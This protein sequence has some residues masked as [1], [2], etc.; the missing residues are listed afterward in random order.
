MYSPADLPSSTRAA[1]AK[2]RKWSELGGS[3][4]EAVRPIGLPVSRHSTRVISSARASIAS[5]I[6]SSASER[7]CGVVCPQRLERAVGGGVR[8]VD[9]LGAR[10]RGVGVDL[11]RGRVDDVVGLP[12]DGVDEL[13]VDDVAEGG[14][15]AMCPVLRGGRRVEDGREVVEGARRA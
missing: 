6:L 3:S 8:P 13:A 15:L 10:H 12:R 1:P 2:N 11:A 4:S 9:V 5:A 14:V 7:S